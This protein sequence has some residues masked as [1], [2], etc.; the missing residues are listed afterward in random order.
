[1][2]S[3][4]HPL[5][6]GAPE[7]PTWPS[8]PAPPRATAAE[9]ARRD[10]A[11]DALVESVAG[12]D[13]VQTTAWASIRQRL[14]TPV[15]HL[16]VHAGDGTLL[17]GCLMQHR[18][19]LP[20]IRIGAVPRGPLVF[21]HHPGAAEQVVREMIAT[22]R[23][24]GIRLLVVQPPGDDT[25]L[26]QALGAAGFRIG[27]PAIAPTATVR[28]DLRRSEAELLA[29]LS[30]TRRR[31]VRQSQRE[32]LETAV[33]D[34]L[35]AFHRLHVASAARQGFQPLSLKNLEAQR[36]VLAPLGMHRML[37]T[38]HDGVPVAG[39]WFTV[40][41][42]EW[43]SKLRGSAAAQVAPPI[44][45]AATGAMWASI[46]EA[47]R[48]GAHRFDFGGFDRGSAEVVLAGRELP[49]TFVDSPSHFKW[50]FGGEIVLLPQPRF[51]LTGRIA[52]AALAG[53][54]Q[55]VLAG[56]AA[57]R[58]AQTIRAAR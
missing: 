34:D 42:G 12:G 40:F 27:A 1:M 51:I 47:R 6:A 17:G 2:T 13:L 19:V 39:E 10:A 7:A 15:C 18:R 8:H 50:S 36:D 49:P 52:H 26:D 38:R 20:G 9:E 5:V 31:R 21:A 24:L 16:R 54:L 37:I 29:G 43:T 3:R 35:E 28:L 14:G 44:R 4:I 58:L 57:R 45:N 46:L 53:L 22:A 33:S 30:A 25:A 23:R 41:G 11:W 48:A 56:D 55:R 32:S